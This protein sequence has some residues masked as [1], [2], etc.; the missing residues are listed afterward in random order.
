[1]TSLARATRSQIGL[2]QA[3]QREAQALLLDDEHV[4]PE[5]SKLRYLLL[6]VAAR[7]VRTSRR[8]YLRIAQRWPWEQDLA[9]A[10]ARLDAL[11][12]PLG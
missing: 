8:T 10:I 12:R 5:P 11:P 3:H 6:H 9:N 2:G 7:L 4:L 1:M